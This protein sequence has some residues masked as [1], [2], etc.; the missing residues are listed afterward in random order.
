MRGEEGGYDPRRA[1]SFAEWSA[2]TQ[3][4]STGV[5]RIW[6]SIWGKSKK[7]YIAKGFFG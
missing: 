2:G 4:S 5:L 3:G 6:N 7:M 1:S